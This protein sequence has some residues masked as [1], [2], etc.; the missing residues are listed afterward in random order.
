MKDSLCISK[1]GSK[2]SFLAATSA[3]FALNA[4]SALAA[5]VISKN[6]DILN[7]TGKKIGSAT[8]VETRSG[9]KISLTASDL[10]PG[11][12]AVHIHEKGS[13]EGP[14]FKSAGGH[15][16]PEKKAHGMENP[17]GHHAGDL[18]NITVGQDGSVKTD[19]LDRDVTLRPNGPHSLVQAQGAALVIHEKADDEKS[20]PA[21]NAGGR[22]ACGVI[23]AVKK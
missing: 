5:N 22:V 18:K 13:C 15:F 4:S 14:D 7:A 12:H 23:S 11:V 9:V 10:T 16:N 3:I 2:S 6:I 1:F 19:L 20:D 8:L 21:G 17:Q